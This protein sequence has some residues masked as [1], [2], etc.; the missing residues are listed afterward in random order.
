V[1]IFYTIANFS[2][3]ILSIVTTTRKFFTVVISIFMYNHPM[4]I[5]QWM[6]IALV[7]TG[8]FIEMLSGNKKHAAK[9]D[10]QPLPTTE[11]S[12]A[13][14]APQVIIADETA[15]AT[16]RNNQQGEHNLTTKSIATKPFGPSKLGRAKKYSEENGRT[17]IGSNSTER[18]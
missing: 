1:F 3:L 14:I 17:V 4:N 15:T 18:T 6:S 13:E 11:T 9:K 8:V 16:R 7:F 5:Y 2:P 10:H 12:N